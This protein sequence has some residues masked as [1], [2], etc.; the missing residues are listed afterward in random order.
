MCENNSVI[1][2]DPRAPHSLNGLH[3]HSDCVNVA[4]FLDEHTLFTGSDD[5]TV[6]RWDLR[7][8]ACVTTM[9]GHTGWVKNIEFTSRVR[10]GK[11]RPPCSTRPSSRTL[12]LPRPACRRAPQSEALTCGF[13]G[14]VRRW[15]L[16]A[17]YEQYTV[18]ARGPPGALP[19]FT[20]W[21]PP[22]APAQSRLE[23]EAMGTLRWT[24][25]ARNNNVVRPSARALRGGPQPA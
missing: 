25:V 22:I 11:S 15:D 13:D 17:N 23:F 16:N 9:R 14:T 5:C 7:R 24:P 8:N 4:R 19:P 1:V 6:K 3:S 20:T 10:A 21:S 12:E 2:A 18:R